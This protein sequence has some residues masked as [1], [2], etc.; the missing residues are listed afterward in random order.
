MPFGKRNET[1]LIHV[2]AQPKKTTRKTTTAEVAVTVAAPKLRTFIIKQRQTEKKKRIDR[3]T[4]RYAQIR[5]DN[6]KT[7]CRKLCA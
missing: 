1:H 2:A 5:G 7:K 4:T 3:A 6:P